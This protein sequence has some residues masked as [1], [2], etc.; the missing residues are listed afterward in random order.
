SELDQFIRD[1]ND[2]EGGNVPKYS[3]GEFKALEDR[4]NQTYQQFMATPVSGASYLGTIRKSGV[5][6]TQHAWL[7]FRDAMELFGSMKYPSAPASGLRAL[8]TSRRLKQLM[9][10]ENAAVGR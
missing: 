5:E 6:K 8:L 3:E 7:A 2:F 9:E 10:L 1:I 4:M